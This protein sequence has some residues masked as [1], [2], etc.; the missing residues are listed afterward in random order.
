[1]FN[2]MAKMHFS[3]TKRFFKAAVTDTHTMLPQILKLEDFITPTTLP[4]ML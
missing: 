4:A 2:L 3:F 1:M